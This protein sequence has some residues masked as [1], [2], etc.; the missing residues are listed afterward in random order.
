MDTVEQQPTAKPG[1]MSKITGAVA[2]HP[3]MSLV[4]IIVLLVCVIYLVLADKFG[5]WKPLSGMTSGS[6]KKKVE[7]KDDEEIDSL[8]N[9][10]HSKQ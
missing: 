6:G 2:S 4:I 1:L 10:I 5:W 9:D 7:E 3:M 8:I